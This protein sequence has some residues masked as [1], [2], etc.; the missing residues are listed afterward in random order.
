M[1]D[2]EKSEKN[3]TAITM[4]EA[5]VCAHFNAFYSHLLSLVV[6]VASNCKQNC[7]LLPI[8]SRMNAFS[9]CSLSLHS[10][11]INGTGAVFFFIAAVLGENARV[12]M[13]AF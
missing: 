1:Q 5:F 6:V 13:S 3:V 2:N 11:F 7:F 8:K 4:N 9:C 12:L 10:V